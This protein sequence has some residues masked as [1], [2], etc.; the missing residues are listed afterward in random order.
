MTHLKLKLRDG[1]Q[2]NGRYTYI[3][4]NLDNEDGCTLLTL[5]QARRDTRG[6]CIFETYWDKF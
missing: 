6:Q 4:L 2:R 5:D 3:E 1:I